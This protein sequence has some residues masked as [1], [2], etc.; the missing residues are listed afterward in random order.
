MEKCSK[1][2]NYKYMTIK[3]LTVLLISVTKIKH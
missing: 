1:N 2:I 3:E